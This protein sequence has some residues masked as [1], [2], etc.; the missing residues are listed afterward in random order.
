MKRALVSTS[1][2]LG[3]LALSITGYAGDPPKNAKT[4]EAPTTSASLS[5]L[6]DG[7]KWQS[8][9]AELVKLYNGVG[10]RFDQ[11]YD[12]LLLKA[13][14]GVQQKA[15]EFDRDQR[16]RA[17]EN[18]RV[19]FKDTPTGYDSTPI[20]GEYTYKNNESVMSVE[21]NGTRTYF[22]FFGQPPGDRLWK[23]YREV[24][25][26]EGGAYGNTF[27]ECVTKLNTQLGVAG[28]IRAADA[29]NGLSTTEVD[30]Q[31]NETHLR[32]LD[33]SRDKVCAL[34]LEHRGTL[35]NLGALRAAKETDPFAIDPSIANVTKGGLSDPNANKGAPAASGKKPGPQPPAQKK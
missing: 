35:N 3:A 5:S 15:I 6:M 30:W 18:S 9:S 31:D 23:I 29:N 20:R 22:F 8:S 25:L 4:Q 12:A 34:V 17:F 27:Q 24:R 11:D 10:G 19:E 32:A 21:R 14:P 33:R 28:R 26:S 1:L 2:L 13:Q 16:K 7:A